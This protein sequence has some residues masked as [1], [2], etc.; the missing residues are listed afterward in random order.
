MMIRA[1]GK[2]LV[3]LIPKVYDTQRVIKILAEDDTE[4]DVSVDPN[5]E[6][7]AVIKKNQ[8]T[9]AIE[10]V[11]FNPNVGTYDVEADMGPDYATRRQEAENAYGQLMSADKGVTPI[12]GD[13]Y[14]KSLDFPGADVAAE[15]LKRMVP[16]QALGLA[17]SPQLQQQ[18][19]ELTKQNTS[20][21]NVVSELTKINAENAI[22]L[23]GKDEL[24]DIEAFNAG[25]KDYEAQTKRIQAEADA[26][27]KT[28]QTAAIAVDA[29]KAAQGLMP[30]DD[31]DGVR[32]ANEKELEPV[33]SED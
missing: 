29:A 14:V 3:D 1:I 16:P 12:I 13:L 10:S 6:H 32:N 26:R 2:A 7:A 24:R 30:Q 17:P 15:R 18:I 25:T 19:Q 8:E 31:L 20:L 21:M 28:H 9:G 33:G 11:L 4:Q 5:S 27:Q 23:K 22:K